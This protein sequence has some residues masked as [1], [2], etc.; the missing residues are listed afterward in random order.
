MP[1]YKLH[2]YKKNCQIMS[3]NI[4]LLNKDTGFWL[5]YAFTAKC[6]YEQRLQ[7]K[8]RTASTFST[9]RKFGSDAQWDNFLSAK[10][11]NRKEVALE[12]I[13]YFHNFYHNNVRRNAVAFSRNVIWKLSRCCHLYSRQYNQAAIITNSEFN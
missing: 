9:D 4:R 11:S 5:I 2:S 1:K 10:R 12:N 3:V 13:S 6:S 7:A 8:S